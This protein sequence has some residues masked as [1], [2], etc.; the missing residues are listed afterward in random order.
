M[1]IIKII[2]KVIGLFIIHY[3]ILIYTKNYYIA[4]KTAFFTFFFY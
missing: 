3:S 1:K 4:L 2:F